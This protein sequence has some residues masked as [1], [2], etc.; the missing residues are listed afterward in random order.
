MSKVKAPW[1]D[2]DGNT[3]YA[4]DTIKHPSGETGKVM[5]VNHGG[6]NGEKW[7]VDYGV[8]SLSLLSLQIGNKGQAV[9]VSK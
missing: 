7:F 1:P 4:G 9:V 3:I 2:F 5:Y 8:A 6:R